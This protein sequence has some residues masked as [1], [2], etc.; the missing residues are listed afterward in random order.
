MKEWTIEQITNIF[1]QKESGI[2]YFYTPMCG[3]C[4][5]AGKM[6]TI[7]EK[8]LPNIKIAKANLNFLPEIAADLSIESVPCLLFISNGVV[9]DKIYAFQSVPYLYEKIKSFHQC[10]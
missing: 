3:T 2:V 6:T 1:E 10:P 4:Q 7:V 9:K 8:T 5:V